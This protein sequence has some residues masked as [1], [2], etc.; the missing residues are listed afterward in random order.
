MFETWTFMLCCALALSVYFGVTSARQTEIAKLRKEIDQI[1]G[2]LDALLT[3]AGVKYERPQVQLS[4]A[5][6]GA[7]NGGRK[8]EAIKLLR[9][10]TGMGLADA[11]EIIEEH[12]R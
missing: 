6:Q 7:V 1:Q 9:R 4:P 12:M 5:V 10:E 11:K 3:Q 2:K 8:I